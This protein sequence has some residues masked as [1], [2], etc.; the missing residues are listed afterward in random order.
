MIDAS[1]SLKWVLRDEEHVAQATALR[2]GALAGGVRLVA[3]PLW[4]YEVATG[5]IVAARQRRV[6][7]EFVVRALLNVL[8]VPIGL[9]AP[10]PGDIVTHARRHGISGFD[11]AY[12]ALAERLDVDLWIGDYL[13]A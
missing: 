11:A 5:L 6:S 10:E 7:S 3:P 13:P 8:E 2:D 9:V 1:V 12:L 4:T